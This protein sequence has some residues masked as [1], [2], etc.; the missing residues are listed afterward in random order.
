MIERLI[1]NKRFPSP[2]ILEGSSHTAWIERIAKTALC[3]D[4]SACGICSSCKLIASKNHPDWIELDG[5][6][7][8]ESLRDRLYELQ[9][10]PFQARYRVLSFYDFHK[11]S[12]NI[13]NALLKTLE[14][15]KTDWIILLGSLS[16]SRILP[17]ILSRCL[18]IK[19]A[20]DARDSTSHSEHL[21]IFSQ[22]E[23]G[24][25]LEFYNEFEALFKS[26][27]KTRST[28]A[29][30]LEMASSRGYPG[31]WASLAPELLDAIHLLDRNLQPKILWER[32]WNA[33]NQSY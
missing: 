26:K 10:R 6:I 19:L 4:L 32:A 28:W 30:L 12:A 7:K 13:Q 14:E 9:R 18:K 31:F 15:P 8:M 1:E 33:A 16:I 11:S 17:T 24:I 3:R 20:F 27:E 23:N 2:L 22:I 5:G 21:H 25:D 29:E